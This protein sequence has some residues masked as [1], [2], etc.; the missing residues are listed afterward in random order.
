MD[1]LCNIQNQNVNSRLNF[2]HTSRGIQNMLTLEL[3]HFNFSPRNIELININA[4]IY[5][6]QQDVVIVFLL[7]YILKP[8]IVYLNVETTIV[9]FYLPREL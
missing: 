6:H 4:N 2:I 1:V 8:F 9:F 7:L 5:R 3:L